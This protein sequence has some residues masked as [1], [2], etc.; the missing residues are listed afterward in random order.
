MGRKLRVI[1]MSDSAPNMAL[2][3]IDKARRDGISLHILTS[4]FLVLSI[5]K[6]H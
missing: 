4:F 2:K 1:E 5:S 3:S 6:T